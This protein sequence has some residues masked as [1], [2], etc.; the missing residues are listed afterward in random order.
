[1]G[2]FITLVAGS[3]GS[4]GS[5]SDVDTL[6]WMACGAMAFLFVSAIVWTIKRAGGGQRPKR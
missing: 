6:G 1:M 5:W 3:L 4:D 2:K